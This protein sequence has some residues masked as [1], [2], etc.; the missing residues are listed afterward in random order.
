VIAVDTLPPAVN[1]ISAS[2][3]NS[4]TAAGG[5]VTFTNLGNLA[6]GA[7][8]NLTVIVQPTAAG[9]ITDTASCRSGVIDPL[10]ANNSASVKTIVQSLSLTV[11]RADQSL[12]MSWPAGAGNYSLESTTDL[13]PPAVWTPVTNPPP[14]V[15]GGQNT[16]TIPMGSGSEFFRL[17]GTP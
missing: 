1:F 17:R 10:K 13:M 12:V 8:I 2:P 3:A 16:V 7:Q 6:S 15:V 11:I 9:T 4:Y 14:T 5:V